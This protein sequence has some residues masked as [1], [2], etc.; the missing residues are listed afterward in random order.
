[1]SKLAVSRVKRVGIIQLNDPESLNCLDQ[2]TLAEILRTCE[3]FDDDAGISV[4]L[5]RGNPE[6]FSAGGDI[7]EMAD[8]T[9]LEA[10]SEDLFRFGQRV[11]DIRKPMIAA[12]QGFALGGGCELAL[13]CDIIV[14]AESARFGQPEVKLGII[15]GMGG[16]QRLSRAVGKYKAMDMCLTGRYLTAQEAEHADLV[17]RVVPDNQIEQ[18]AL[19]IAAAISEM[20]LPAVLMAKEAINT[21]FESHLSQGLLFERRSFHSLFATED[22]KEGMAAFQQKR[23]P[24]FTNK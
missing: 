18:V 21:S 6:A 10:F 12:V 20:P 9:S 1:M 2:E 22:Q 14:A 17:A 8:K 7:K 5:I 24:N 3:D 15:P 23:S 11:L 19:E 13:S 4:I 16:T